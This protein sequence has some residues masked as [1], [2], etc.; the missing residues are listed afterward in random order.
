M[1][2]DRPPDFAL[3]DVGLVREKTFAIAERLDAPDIPYAFVTGY[4]TDVSLP[5]ALADKV[6]L[7]K[8]CSSEALKAAL[9]CRSRDAARRS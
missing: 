7:T 1:I 9:Q 3:L 5:A 4:G 6:R 8:P 2:A